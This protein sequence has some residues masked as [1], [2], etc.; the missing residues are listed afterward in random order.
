MKQSYKVSK[1]EIECKDD[2]KISWRFARHAMKGTEFLYEVKDA[3]FDRLNTWLVAVRVPKDVFGDVIVEPVQSPGKKVWAELVRRSIVLSRATKPDFRSSVYCKVN[4]A[5]PSGWQTKRGTRR[6]D[7]NFLPRWFQPFRW[8]MRLKH[9]V[10]TTRGRDANAQIVLMDRDDHKTMIKLYFA[11][12]V[13]VLE[14]SF[15]L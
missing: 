7:R 15:S 4:L 11:L 1:L 10:T 8:R 2:R 3:N 14:E 9:T 12:K 6:G 13:W 5:D